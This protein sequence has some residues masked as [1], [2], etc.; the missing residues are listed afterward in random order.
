MMIVVDRKAHID[1]VGF[2]RGIEHNIRHAKFT[3]ADTLKRWVGE[4]PARKV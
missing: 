1:D 4:N 3:A 2:V